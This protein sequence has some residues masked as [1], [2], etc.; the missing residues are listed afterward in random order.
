M[1]DALAAFVIFL[2]DFIRW[3]LIA[4]GVV[5][6]CTTIAALIVIAYELVR[7]MRDASRF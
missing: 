7:D 4:I 3:G 1:L 6:I 5:L 2:L